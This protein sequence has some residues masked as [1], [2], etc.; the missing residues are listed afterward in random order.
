MWPL[1]AA[2]LLTLGLAA[3]APFG[4]SAPP[5]WSNSPHKVCATTTGTTTQP[6]TTTATVPTTTTATTTTMPTTTTVTTTS[7]SPLGSKLPARMP[8]SD[9]PVLSVAPSGGGTTCTA[10]APCSLNTAWSKAASGN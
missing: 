10:S 1:A 7:A 6:T 5:C 4:R 8:E 2:G 9:G 3:A